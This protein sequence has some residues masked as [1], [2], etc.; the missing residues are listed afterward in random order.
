MECHCNIVGATGFELRVLANCRLLRPIAMCVGA[1]TNEPRHSGL[2][3]PTSANA[4]LR[5][6]RQFLPRQ[7]VG[8]APA[9]RVCGC[10]ACGE[11]SRRT[12]S[13][14]R[15]RS[16]FFRRRPARP[17]WPHVDL[18]VLVDGEHS[19]RR[20]H[21]IAHWVKDAFRAVEPK[22]L[23]AM[24]HPP[25]LHSIRGTC[26]P[27]KEPQRRQDRAGAASHPRAPRRVSL[28][29]RRTCLPRRRPRL[30]SR[31]LCR[32]APKR[33]ANLPGPRPRRPLE[34]RAE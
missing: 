1:S 18:H 30:D 19:V 10:K 2:D 4:A 23:D 11:S 28:D 26:G 13:P 5:P 8:G 6:M 29:Q 24:I 7:L 31:H 17:R 20:G 33:R 15:S 21:A 32:P 9:L 3:G 14:R 25:R 12:M 22:L 27:R 34:A 16:R